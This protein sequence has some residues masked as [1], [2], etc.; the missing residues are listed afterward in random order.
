MSVGCYHRLPRAAR[1][2]YKFASPIYKTQTVGGPGRDSRTLSIVEQ[3]AM[4][5]CTVGGLVSGM[6]HGGHIC[7]ENYK[8]TDIG[9]LAPVFA[10]S[11]GPNLH[12]EDIGPMARSG[13]T[14]G[15]APDGS[16]PEFTYM[17]G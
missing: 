10:Y 13:Q 4:A 9:G 2:S 15:T 12:H 16:I 5:P 11:H 3:E 1:Q 14:L 6:A 7:H 8:F 17:G